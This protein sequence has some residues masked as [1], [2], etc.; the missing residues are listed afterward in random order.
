[1][2]ALP[3]G[4]ARRRFQRTIFTALD[5]IATRKAVRVD[6]SR[7]YEVSLT[8]RFRYQQLQRVECS[9]DTSLAS[10]CVLHQFLQM[11]AHANL[12]SITR[13]AGRCGDEEAHRAYTHLQSWSVTRE[14]RM[15]ICHAGQ[16]LRNARVIR[17][18][19]FRG[20]DSFMVYY[21]VMVLWTYSMLLRDRAGKAI[22]PGEAG[23]LGTTG[24]S[25]VFLDNPNSNT[26]AL[27]DTFVSTNRGTPGLHIMAIHPLLSKE[28]D[29]YLS[30]RVCDLRVPSQ[31]MEVGTNLFG[32]A[33]PSVLTNSGPPLIRALSSLMRELGKL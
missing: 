9:L 17:P 6:I 15:A 5:P 14:A 3:A 21:A 11:Y 4:N 12:D 7:Q 26:D 20:P 29:P 23:N 32:A 31:V 30:A 10:A 25:I 22:A 19:Q 2:G 13:F 16:V 8:P 24:N 28:G 33:H 27:R 18:Y 1:M